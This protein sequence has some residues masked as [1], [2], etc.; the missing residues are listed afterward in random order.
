MSSDYRSVR[1]NSVLVWSAVA[2]SRSLLRS[3]SARRY[4]RLSLSTRRIHRSTPSSLCMSQRVFSFQI[5]RHIHFDRSNAYRV[6]RQRRRMSSIWN[7]SSIVDWSRVRLWKSVSVLNVDSST[8]NVSMNWFDTW[9]SSVVNV[10]FFSLGF[11]RPIDS[12]WRITWVSIWVPMA[13]P[14][15]HCFS[16][17]KPKLNYRIR[18]IIFN[19][20]SNNGDNSSSMLKIIWRMSWN[21]TLDWNYRSSIAISRCNPSYRLNCS[22]YERRINCWNRISRRSCWRN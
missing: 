16:T 19:S 7:N 1:T 9:L 21:Y 13:T 18:S 6:I 22:N 3:V 2:T 5:H 15:E 8:M 4:S 14:C 10:V 17:S 20:T 11:V 12:W